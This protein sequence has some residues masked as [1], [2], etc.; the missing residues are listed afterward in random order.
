MSFHLWR[1]VWSCLRVR[2]EAGKK[3]KKVDNCWER[4]LFDRNF[5]QQLK[6]PHL[7]KV[8]MRHLSTSRIDRSSP[9]K[10]LRAATEW[11]L[12]PSRRQHPTR[13]LIAVQRQR[14]AAARLPVKIISFRRFRFRQLSISRCNLQSESC[15]NYT[16]ESFYTP[17][18]RRKWKSMTFS[19]AGCTVLRGLSERL[20]FSDWAD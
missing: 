7:K 18:R 13:R 12:V 17:E 10:A 14:K 20:L 4:H 15:C 19:A 3:K 1:N 2:L 11:N 8:K 6:Q 9:T 5:P 16:P